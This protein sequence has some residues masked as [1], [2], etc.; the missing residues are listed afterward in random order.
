VM[1]SRLPIGVETTYRVPGIRAGFP[2]VP[3]PP[4]VVL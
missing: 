1:S 3:R 4:D 2:D